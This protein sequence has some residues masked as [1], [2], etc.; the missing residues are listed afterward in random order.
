ML[1]QYLKLMIYISLT[2]VIVSY[3]FVQAL[4]YKG[5]KEIQVTKEMVFTIHQLKDLHTMCIL[6][7]QYNTGD[8]ITLKE[9]KKVE[10]TIM[11]NLD[12]YNNQTPY[13]NFYKKYLQ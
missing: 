8:K 7:Y 5:N 2:I 12:N 9:C 4:I 13:L 11:T 10:K 6:D 1:K 3:I